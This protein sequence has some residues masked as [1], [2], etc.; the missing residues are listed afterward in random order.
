[1]IRRKALFFDVL[2]ALSALGSAAPVLAQSADQSA[3]TPIIPGVKTGGSR[4]IKVLSHLPLDSIE[5]TA[6][7]TMEQELSRPYV[8]TSH[9]LIPSGVDIISIKDPGK[10]RLLWSWRIEN[11]ELHR[12]AGSLNTMYL[13]SKGRYYLT[14]SFQ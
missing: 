11:A 4:N 10:P 6:D 9:R 13:K 3:P 8:Y 2:V 5:K 7:I 12:G 1:M 14:N